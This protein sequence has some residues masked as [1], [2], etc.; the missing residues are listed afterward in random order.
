A[1]PD[2]VKLFELPHQSIEGKTIY[3]I[4]IATGVNETEAA[5]DER[6]TFLLMG[7]HHARE[8]P[9]GEHTM[10]FAHDLVQGHAAGDARISRLVEEARTVLI[11]VVNVDGFE[12]SVNDGLTLDLREFNDSDPLGGTTSILATPNNAYKRKNCR[13]EENL[14][15]LPL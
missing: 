2:I 9:S 7:L 8:W 13:I 11:P 14:D 10:E 4:E 3:G 1:H 5:A 6:P 15:G 12:K